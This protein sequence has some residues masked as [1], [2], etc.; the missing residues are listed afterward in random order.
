MFRGRASFSRYISF[1]NFFLSCGPEVHILFEH[2]SVVL[3]AS[4]FCWNNKDE[5][6]EWFRFSAY[7]PCHTATFNRQ[8]NQVHLST[9]VER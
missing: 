5:Q 6:P 9:S 3:Q 4:K 7:R 1:W 2:Y 8:L